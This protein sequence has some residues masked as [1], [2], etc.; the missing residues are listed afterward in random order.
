MQEKRK[1]LTAPRLK[2]IEGRF[3]KKGM[4]LGFL[5]SLSLVIAAF[6]TAC[7]GSSGRVANAAVPA[8]DN[9]YT[10]QHATF[11]MGCF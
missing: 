8:Y 7:N 3:V 10:L 2:P 5:L 1:I 6:A 9:D 11:G 4:R